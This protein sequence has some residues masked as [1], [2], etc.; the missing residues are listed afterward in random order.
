MSFSLAKRLKTLP[1]YLFAELDKKKSALI[2]KKMD[3]INLSIGD[4]D[5]ATP[6]PI[7][8]A[9][10]MAAANP[11][12][13]SYPAYNGCKAFRDAACAWMHSHYQ[14]RFDPDRE[15]VALIGSKEGIAHLP[16]A[17]VNPGDTVL[18][19]DPG[20]PVYGSST[21]FVGGTVHTMPLRAD[22][23][24]LPDLSAIPADVAQ[25]A[26]LMHL[27]YP[28]NPTSACAP[29]E[30]FEEV[31]AFAKE[32]NIIV[33]HDAAY[34]EI[35]YD[36]ERPLS[37][38]QIDGARDV[39]IEFHSLSKTF[40]MTGWRSGFAVGNPELVAGLAKMKTN[41]DSG[42]FTAVQHASVTALTT[43]ASCVEGIRENYQRRRD[44]LV[45]GL[46]K[47]GWQIEAP[48]ATF[49]VWTRVPGSASSMAYVSRLMDTTGVILTPGIGFGHEG[50]Q[51]IR[52]ALT[53]PEARLEEAVAR[54][55]KCG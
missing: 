31:V 35:F 34:L 4:P 54:I 46:R 5:V 37:I 10:R 13:H 42:V 33:A 1:P 6:A 2:A 49:Y 43:A 8:E 40:N 32:H 38:F 7:V 55:A 36:D 28:N 51:Y 47:I 16:W 41:I 50:D 29:R 18:V 30:F 44:C 12:N 45:A 48:A 19:P 3:L 53:A 52:F 20:Y 21:T 23:G 22:R 14:Q 24:F 26:R 39:A 27:N 11:A 17:F 15:C 9:M 25:N